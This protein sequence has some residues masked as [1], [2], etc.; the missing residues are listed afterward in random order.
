MPLS[1]KDNQ[2]VVRAAFVSKPRAWDELLRARQLLHFSY[3]LEVTCNREGVAA[4]CVRVSELYPL[5]GV[6][7]VGAA[8][9]RVL[10]YRCVAHSAAAPFHT[11]Q[12]N[13]AV[14]GDLANL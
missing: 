3:A 12:S 9:H 4:E 2:R 11:V 6:A 7:R 1:F 13:A 14:R 10:F 5:A 8:H